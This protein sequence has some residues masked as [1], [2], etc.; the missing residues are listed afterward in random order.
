M[1]KTSLELKEHDF[2]K[3]T[4]RNPNESPKT[5]LESTNVK[6]PEKKNTIKTYNE[7]VRMVINE[8]NKDRNGDHSSNFGL[9]ITPIKEKTG[10]REK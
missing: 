7:F 8:E 3:Y 5:L 10:D 2:G 1:K 6:K 9:N 4:Q